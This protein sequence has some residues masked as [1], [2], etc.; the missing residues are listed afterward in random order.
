MGV[1]AEAIAAQGIR[2]HLLAK[3]PAKVAEVNAL[4]GAVL[5]A[6]VAGPY[7]IPS[8]GGQVFTVRS[9]T[10]TAETSNITAGSRTAA[11]IVTDIGSSLSAI[12]VT[13]TADTAG[14]LVFTST[15]AP[16][17]ADSMVGIS[18]DSTNAGMNAALGFDTA[19][20]EVT[21]APLVT[22][23]FRGVADGWPLVP[24]LGAGFWVIINDR[25]SAPV[26]PGPRSD[27]Y[28]VALEVGIFCPVTNV[29][30]HR[31]R[32]AIQA[33]MRCVR[34]CLLTDAGRQ[35]GRASSGD[36]MLVT[37]KAA[38]IPGKPWKFRGGENAPNAL[39]DV[40]AMQLNVRVFERPASS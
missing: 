35:A 32:E 40:A 2:E 6:P 9:Q 8:L 39:F 20:E 27:E 1:Q 31:D 17:S 3:L 22:P 21:R 12:N 19:G 15:S 38:R 13:P 26:A 36:I 24:D 14:H 7:T 18:S 33:C 23:G 28:L 30:V 16:T 29:Q 4:R 34:E 37:E 11:Q 10:G 25:E 5:R